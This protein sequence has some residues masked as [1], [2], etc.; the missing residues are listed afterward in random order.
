MCRQREAEFTVSL[1][2]RSDAGESAADPL[3]IEVMRRLNPE[4]APYAAGVRVTPVEISA[5]E[6]IADADAIRIDMHFDFAYP[7]GDWKLTE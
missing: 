4:T 5:D 1:F 6:E 3:R 2:V 7:A